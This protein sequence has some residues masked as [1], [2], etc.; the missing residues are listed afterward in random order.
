MTYIINREPFFNT[1]YAHELL[2][3]ELSLFGFGVSRRDFGKIKN[4][5][6]SI[7]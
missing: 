4:T 7:T 5:L 3:I 6:N 2:T 1:F